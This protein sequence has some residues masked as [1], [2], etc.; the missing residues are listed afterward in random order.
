MKTKVY[1]VT[2]KIKTDYNI[3]EL[4][5]VLEK[6]FEIP[7]MQYDDCGCFEYRKVLIT[8]G[9]NKCQTT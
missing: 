2:F 9:G 5:E 7:G 8:K 1:I 3:K 4:E 6:I